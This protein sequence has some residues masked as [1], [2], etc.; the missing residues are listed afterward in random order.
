MLAAAAA[1]ASTSFAGPALAEDSAYCRKVRARAASDASLLIAPTV[2]AEGVRVPAALQKGAR[3]D[4]TTPGSG[5]QVRAGVSFS[6]VNAYKGIRVTDVG[7]ADC[8]QHEYT[9]KA[10]N[11]LLQ[12]SDLGRLEALRRQSAALEARQS[13]IAAVLSRIE[14]RFEAKNMTL[15]EV[16]DIRS[17]VSTLSRQRA[18]LAG[19]IGRLEAAGYE[20]YR[21]TVSDLAKKVEESSLSFESKANH[22]RALDAWDVSVSAGYV[23]P[24]LGY[25][26]DF[27]GVVQVSYSLGSPWH[28]SYDS[29]YLS[30]RREEVKTAR[31]EVAHRLEVLRGQVRAAVAQARD[32]LRIVDKRAAEVEA[33]RSTLQSVEA[34]SAAH[35]QAIYDLQR[36]GLEAE[37]VY[38]TELV[39]ELSRIE[40][41]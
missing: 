9:V 5:Y 34:P 35:A 38:I 15:I 33:S 14:G 2:L 3:L 7:D 10:Q 6:A 36:I 23:P 39:S 22:V 20:S 13:E 37:H 19:E 8:T 32:E 29:Q 25:T 26:G 24:I 31:Y 16:E 1:L 11:L 4:A 21:G 28:D 12:V 17:R 18:A 40:E 41:K 27:F 30:A